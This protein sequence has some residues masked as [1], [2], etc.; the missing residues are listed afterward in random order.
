MVRR[1]ITMIDNIK[2]WCNKILPLVYDDS[3]SYYE[4]LCK[5][6]AKLNEVITST[7]GLLDAW[8][9]YNTAIAAAF[10]KYTAELDK[11]F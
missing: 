4:V 11:K 10:G 7:N 3:L 9:T 5:T 1:L 2:Y 6:S 8:D